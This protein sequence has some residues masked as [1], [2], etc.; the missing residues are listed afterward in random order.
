MTIIHAYELVP[1]KGETLLADFG[2]EILCHGFWE[3]G[4]WETTLLG[5][6]GMAWLQVHGFL[7]GK[8]EEKKLRAALIILFFSFLKAEFYRQL[9]TLT[10]TVARRKRKEKIPVFTF[11]ILPW[12]TTMP[13]F[14]SHPSKTIAQIFLL[15]SKQ[16]FGT[17]CKKRC[18]FA[19]KWI[20]K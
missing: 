16:I 10:L 13:S 7:H 1:A 18:Q 20:E 6:F 9:S 12:R 14:L 4:S 11:C 19:P 8:C 17:M 5:K 3:L 2:C 15:G